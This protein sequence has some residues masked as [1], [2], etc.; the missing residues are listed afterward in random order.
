MGEQGHKV[1][2]NHC[3]F[4]LAPGKTLSLSSVSPDLHVEG[5]VTLQEV[6]QH[7]LSASVGH[8]DAFVAVGMPPNSTHYSILGGTDD[9]IRIYRTKPENLTICQNRN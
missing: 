8:G 6:L 7:T 1:K 2:K 5:W 3:V 4:L 9:E